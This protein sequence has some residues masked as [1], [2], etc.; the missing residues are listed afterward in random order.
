MRTQQEIKEE[1]RKVRD[2]R[3]KAIRK[4]ERCNDRLDELE[5]ELDEASQKGECK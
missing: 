4:V 2:A 1:I 5:I 3:K